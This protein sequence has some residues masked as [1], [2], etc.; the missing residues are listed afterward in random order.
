MPYLWNNL[1]KQNNEIIHKQNFIQMGQS[2]H[3][4]SNA[5]GTVCSQTHMLRMCVRTWY[6]NTCV[7]VYV[8]RE[9][10][11]QTG[12]GSPGHEFGRFALLVTFFG[13]RFGRAPSLIIL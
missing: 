1:S 6:A 9:N 5:A 2:R 13:H 4:N 7:C 11:D 12:Q 8:R 10:C 3:C